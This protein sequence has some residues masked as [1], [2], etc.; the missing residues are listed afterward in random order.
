MKTR[1]YSFISTVLLMMI[2]LGLPACNS[3]EEEIFSVATVDNFLQ[4]EE[5]YLAAIG[6]A[7]TALYP[8]MGISNQWG[9]NEVSS[10]EIVVPRRGFDWGD[11]GHWLRM[12]RHT[13]DPFDPLVSNPWSFLYAGIQACDR[14]TFQFEQVNRPI[15]EPFIAELRGLRAIYYLF[16]LDMYGNVPIVKN[17]TEGE[18]LPENSS[19]QEVFDFVESELQ[20][21]LPLVGSEVGAN[22]YGRVNQMVIRTA[23][24]RL[25]LNAEVYT[26]VPALPEA[27]NAC[28]AVINSGNYALEADYFS[29]FNVDNSAATEAIFAI[30][31]DAQYAGGFSVVHATLHFKSQ[32]TYRLQSQP[33]N[34]FCVVEDFYDSYEDTDLRKGQPNTL[35]GPSRVRGNFLVG[36]QW[37]ESG[38][39]RIVADQGLDRQDSLD[40]DGDLLTFRPEIG[41]LDPWVGSDAGARIGKFEIEKGGS[42][43][44]NNDFAI[45]RYADVLL[46]KAE[47]LWRI[48]PGDGEALALVNQ[49]RERAGG[50]PFTQLTAENLLAERGREL[51]AE[52]TRRTDLIRFGKWGEAWWEKDA[53]DATREIFPIPGVHL[54]ANPNL[55]QNPGY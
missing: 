52:A 46:M 28:N 32:E 45:F 16:L 7:Y 44:M 4:T 1:T 42:S 35:D 43:N 37:D 47:A 50:A 53:S 38:T 34:G 51:F 9:A 25:Y 29:N 19:Q 21:V 6:S 40:M 23:L 17:F 2:M 39:Q 12:H 14:L 49:I 11:G 18:S 54:Q 48:N 33:W 3:I 10:D 55:R 8:F 15:G 22:S 13:W 27:I 31:Y 26:G 41:P 5:E 30:P 36:P 20:E 24:A